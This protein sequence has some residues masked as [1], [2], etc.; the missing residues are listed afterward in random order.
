MKKEILELDGEIVLRSLALVKEHSMYTQLAFP[1]SNR[2]TRTIC[3]ICTELTIK[4]TDPTGNYLFKVNSRNT[5]TL[6]R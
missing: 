5:L 4:A 1:C 2:N 3:E 6:S